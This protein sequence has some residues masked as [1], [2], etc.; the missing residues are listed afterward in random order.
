MPDAYKFV[1]AV[2]VINLA[3][4][5]FNMLPIYPLDGGQI[6]R[7]LLWFG[8]GRARSLMAATVIGFVG[9]AGLIV[10]AVAQQSA[11]LG[12][13]SAFILLNCWSGL[14]HAAG[15]IAL[16]KVAAPRGFCLPVVQGG[17]AGGTVLGLRQVPER[18]RYVSNECRLPELRG[19]VC[20]DQVLGVRRAPSPE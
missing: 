14:Q 18:V 13:I 16:G 6:L 19:A 1:Q 10:L 3:L 2:F 15:I 20:R 12:V 8:I 9:V 7:S 11:W 5:I 4:L 17:A